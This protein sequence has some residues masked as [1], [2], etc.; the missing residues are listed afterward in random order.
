VASQGTASRSIEAGTAVAGGN[1]NDN[2]GVTLA[3]YRP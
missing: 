3:S 2:T 1:A